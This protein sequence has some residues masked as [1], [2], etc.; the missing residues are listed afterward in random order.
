MR[1]K[2]TG[3]TLIE[4]LVVI[5]IIAILA[6]LLLPALQGVRKKAYRTQCLNNHRQI[7]LALQQYSDEDVYNPQYPSGENSN[8]EGLAK[9]A[10]DQFNYVTEDLLNCPSQGSHGVLSSESYGDYAYDGDIS[11]GSYASDSAIVCDQY[12][13]TNNAGNH[14]GYLN[15]LRADLSATKGVNSPSTTDLNNSELADNTNVAAGD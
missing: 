14:T 2:K 15:M 9:L 11:Q 13:F 12:N 4:L 1:T 5:A 6:G 3:F 8:P 7:G 10:E